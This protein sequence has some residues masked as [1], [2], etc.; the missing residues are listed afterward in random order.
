MDKRLKVLFLCTGN[1]CRSQMAEGW[2]R[3]LKSEQIEVFSAGIETHGLNPNA[4]RVMAEAGVDI[5]KHKSKLVDEFR[6][7]E[8]DY[9][10]TV[11]GHAHE[12]C[13][14]FTGKCRIIHAGFDDPPLLARQL[15]AKGADEVAQLECY[16][17]VRD[18]I[19][20]FIETLPEMLTEKRP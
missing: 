4:V 19:K 18:E 8:L 12:T 10:I 14:A 2:T 3:H 16:R 17:I 5:S 7:A 6:N 13:P 1:S 15:S 11:C 20:K 9:V